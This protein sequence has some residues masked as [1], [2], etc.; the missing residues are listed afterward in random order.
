MKASPKN[1]K[2][3]E[4]VK[5]EL[6]NAYKQIDMYKSIVTGLKAKEVS[7]DSIDK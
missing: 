5:K 6:E 4:S 7:V 2:E 1:A 3:V